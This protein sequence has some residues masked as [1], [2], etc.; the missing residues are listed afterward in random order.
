MKTIAMDIDKLSKR[1][2]KQELYLTVALFLITLLVMRVW[3]LNELLVPAI[4]SAAFSLVV[5]TAL[6]LIWRRVAKRS[7]QSL[8]TFFTAASAFRMLLALAVMFVYYL[9]NGRDAM[10]VFFLVF[11]AFYIASLV[12][13][14]FF[15]ARVSSRS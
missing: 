7:P 2:I 11:M 6:A 13:H 15:F 4:V 8:P 10:L 12:H 3:Y 5:A 1:Y 14:S 9:V